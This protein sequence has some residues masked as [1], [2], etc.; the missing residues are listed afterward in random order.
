VYRN[1]EAMSDLRAA[2]KL[3]APQLPRQQA[4]KYY[5]GWQQAVRRVLN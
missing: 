2:G 4:E 3:Y 1:L 5:Q